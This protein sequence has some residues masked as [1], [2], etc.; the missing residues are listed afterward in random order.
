MPQALVTGATEG[1]GHAFARQLA[2]RGHDLILVART[3]SK[4]NRVAE[5]IRHA[6][7][8]HVETIAADLSDDRGCAT[9]EAR[10]VA[11]PPIWTLVN[12]AGIS[13]GGSFLDNDIDEEDR[14]LRLNIRAVLRLTHA[15]LSGMLKRNSGAIINVASVAAYGPV[16]PSSS[17]PASKAWILNFTESLAW[18][19]QLK[20]SRVRIMALLPGYTRTHFHSSADIPTDRIPS[21]MWLDAD[22]VVRKALR[23]LSRGHRISTPT[24]RYKLLAQAVRHLPRLIT[25]PFGLDMSVHGK[26]AETI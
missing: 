14:L 12:N 8:R 1:I 17:Y 6:T 2:H 9:V 13:L 24:M 5:E 15:A 21:W 10:I 4:L 22:L 26:G 23:D 19:R 16:W 7:G 3:G 20:A 11:G 25:V 18:S